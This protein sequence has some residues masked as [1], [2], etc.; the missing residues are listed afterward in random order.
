ME[1]IMCFGVVLVCLECGRHLS[2][3]NLAHQR[4]TASPIERRI[5]CMKMPMLPF[6]ATSNGAKFSAVSSQATR[7]ARS[8]TCAEASPNAPATNLDKRP[9]FYVSISSAASPVAFAGVPG[10]AS[11]FL[12]ALW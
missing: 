1:V 9:E 10:F 8:R 12:A 5:R 4:C 2:S 6:L 3:S 11:S 7:P